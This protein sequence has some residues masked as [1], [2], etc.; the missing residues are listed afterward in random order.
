MVIHYVLLCKA[1]C[2]A[3]LAM[4]FSQSGAAVTRQSTEKFICLCCQSVY[5]K[6][7]KKW[8]DVA[9][10]DA[11]CRVLSMGQAQHC[12]VLTRSEAAVVDYCRALLH[13]LVARARF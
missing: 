3:L 8:T 10:A 5:H 2:I 6:H 4:L 1:R 12:L 9:E 13:T 11:M 7:T